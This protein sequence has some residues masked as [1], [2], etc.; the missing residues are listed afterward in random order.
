[1]RTLTLGLLII[2]LLTTDSSAQYEN[3]SKPNNGY[4]TRVPLYGDSRTKPYII[5]GKVHVREILEN[6]IETFF[7]NK[8]FSTYDYLIKK[9]YVENDP[10]F[11]A[12]EYMTP[13]FITPLYSKKSKQQGIRPMGPM[14]PPIILPEPMPTPKNRVNQPR[15]PFIFDPVTLPSKPK[16]QEKAPSIDDD[17]SAIDNLPPSQEPPEN[18]YDLPVLNPPASEQVKPE[19]TQQEKVKETGKINP[20][21]LYKPFALP[22]WNNISSPPASRNLLARGRAYFQSRNYYQARKTFT[23]FAQTQPYSPYAHFGRAI[24]LLY[25]AE[26]SAALESISESYR[27]A[28]ENNQPKPTVWDMNIQPKDYRKHVR[29][30]LIYVNNNRHDKKAGTLLM[31]VSNAGN[32]PKPGTNHDTIATN[33]VGRT[34]RG[35]PIS[36]H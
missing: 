9:A 26:Y 15:T 34:P 23:K 5:P 19:T 21:Y 4:I 3:R 17:S 27:I 14:L 20:E 11:L 16:Y 7:Q 24:C 6:Q 1:M 8:G 33:N 10:S 25:S 22:G 12:S 13:K 32:V 2:A 36:N 31:L 35:R 29:N 28:K 18:P 30:L